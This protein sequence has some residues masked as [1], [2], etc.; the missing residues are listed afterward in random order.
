MN[1]IDRLG[2]LWLATVAVRHH[3]GEH[4]HRPQEF[5]RAFLPALAEARPSCRQFEDEARQI[6]KRLAEGG[7]RAMTDALD[8]VELLHGLNAGEWIA[9]RWDGIPVGEGEWIS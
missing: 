4:N 5:E 3:D 7:F 2:F 9:R 1:D 8:A 6:G